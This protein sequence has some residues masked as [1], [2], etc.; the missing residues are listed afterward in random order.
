MYEYFLNIFIYLEFYRRKNIIV[1]K[2]VQL[3]VKKRLISFFK[4]A[5]NR[6]FINRL[7]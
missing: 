4:F 2:C 3:L 6:H 1:L 5:L 7:I